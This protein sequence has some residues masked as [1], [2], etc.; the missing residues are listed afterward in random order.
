MSHPQRRKSWRKSWRK[1]VLPWAAGISS[2]VL[3]TI[4]GTVASH[5]FGLADNASNVASSPTGSKII[6]TTSASSAGSTTASA[7]PL[8][9]DDVLKASSIKLS[10]NIGDEDWWA[11]ADPVD[12]SP[13][14]S[15]QLYQM[16]MAN[17][18][19]YS[20]W[21]R[22]RAVDGQYLD[23]EITLTGKHPDCIPGR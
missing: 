19:D 11:S 17:P 14:Q 16:G 2:A 7:T 21:M 6:G 1:T 9:A 15:A 13:E 3:A 5:T 23:T 12:I 8:A 10:R 20:K 18:D 22:E 4:L